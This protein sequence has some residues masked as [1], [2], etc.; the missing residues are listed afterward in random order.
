MPV[1]LPEF[2]F[3]LGTA[4]PGLANGLGEDVVDIFSRNLFLGTLS[5]D[6]FSGMKF[7]Y[8]GP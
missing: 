8:D 5:V 7:K 4:V 3:G 1:L 2:V 6:H